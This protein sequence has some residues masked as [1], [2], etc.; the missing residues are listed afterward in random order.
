MAK[1]SKPRKPRRQMDP[2]HAAARASQHQTKR[3]RRIRIIAILGVLAMV[4]G[5]V[6]GLI[7]SL[8]GGGDVASEDPPA[9]IARIDL[10][11]PPP[12]VQLDE[13]TPCPALNGSSERTTGFIDAPNGCLEQGTNYEATITTEAGDIVIDLNMSEY[14]ATDTFA[15]LAL[16]HFYDGLPWHFILDEGLLFAGATGDPVGTGDIPFRLAAEA[17]ADRSYQ[18]GTVAMI[19]DPNGMYDTRF[20]VSG[21]DDA[22]VFLTTP[23]HP[24]IGEVTEG[25]DVIS[26]IADV[27]AATGSPTEVTR[28]DQITV[29]AVD[30]E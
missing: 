12:G 9:T 17:D 1:K 26:R 13:S 24:V 23:D 8:A 19:T 21:T 29:R 25:L 30:G 10:P 14:E 5:L 4:T 2:A 22:D 27:G 7:G 18:L 11:A 6:A 16:Y 20:L 28:I 15:S 3:Q